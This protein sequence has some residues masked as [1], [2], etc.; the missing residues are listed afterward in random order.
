MPQ[1]NFLLAATTALIPLLMGF[2]WYHKNVFGTAWMKEAGV[3]EEDGKK[4]NMPLVFGLTYLFSFFLS[5]ALHFMTIHQFALFSLSLPEMNY[6]DKG[7]LLP[8][9]NTLA[10]VAGDK[11][12]TF[13]HG[14]VTG[15]IDGFIVILPILGVNALFEGKGWKY[16]LIN[17]GF[18]T[19]CISI[20][21]GIICQWA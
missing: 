14:A 13:R 9:I 16:I 3:T 19:V 12:R 8:T 6:T 7:G 15:F 2:I 4:M 17:T 21:G 5:I 18:W 20:M 10:E 11:Y 1:I